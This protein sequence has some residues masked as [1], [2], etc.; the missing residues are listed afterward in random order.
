MAVVVLAAAVAVRSLEFPH[1][2]NTCAWHVGGA[3]QR[4]A[5]CMR[6]A[7][8]PIRTEVPVHKPAAV[9]EAASDQ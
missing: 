4:S 8:G 3:L 6:Y 5:W 7:A 2:Y 1:M 9:P